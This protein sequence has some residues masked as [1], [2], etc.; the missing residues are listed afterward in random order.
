VQQAAG[1]T[2]AFVERRASSGDERLVEA[3]CRRAC[4][5]RDRQ[6]VEGGIELL[7]ER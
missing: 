1:R 2:E 3:G 4:G 5:E 6:V 7:A